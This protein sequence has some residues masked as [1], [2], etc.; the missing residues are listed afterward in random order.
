[1]NETVVKKDY[2][3][4]YTLLFVLLACTGIA[5]RI[6][7]H[8]FL[9]RALW[10]DEAHLSLN[11]I[12]GNIIDM[13]IPLKHFQSAPIL[14]L[15]SEEIFT[16]IFGFS[17]TALRT[18]P[19]LVSLL[20]YPLYY[21]FV[22]DLTKSRFTAIIAF[23]LL[24]FSAYAIHYSSETK[25][26][27]VELS[28]FIF[29]GFLLFSTNP[30]IA[31]RRE[32]LL[33]VWGSIFMFLANTSLVLLSSVIAYRIYTLL[34]IGKKAHPEAYAAQRK[35]NKKLFT[36]WGISFAADIILNIIINPY[37]D[38][39]RE[40]WEFAYIP[41][42]VF[43][44]GFVDFMSGRIHEIFFS[45]MLLFKDGWYFPYTLQ[46]IMLSGIVYTIR[47]KRFELLF[48]TVLP[49]LLH[50]GLSWMQ[51]YP[52]FFRF[53]LYLFPAIILWVAI[54]TTAIARWISKLH[55]SVA[56]VP[57][58]YILYCCIQP[59]MQQYP[60]TERN[61][62]PVLDFINKY[63]DTTKI[64]ITTPATLYEYYNKT[65]YVKDTNYSGLEWNLSP[66]EYYLS[67]RNQHKN[68]LLLYSDD[69]YAD[70]YARVLKSLKK[71]HMV[72]RAMEYG[73]YGVAELKP[74]DSLR[75]IP[76]A[77]RGITR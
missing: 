51:L 54:G 45:S 36:V 63:P 40:L 55:W 60:I 61:V 25:P 71:H 24:T 69:G 32:K 11:F 39:L 68:Y 33:K 52:L 10:E 74:I 44:T 16:T 76:P 70:G 1:M 7:Q 26:Y 31:A 77:K 73:T 27:T 56:I 9:G 14:F 6:Y 53:V 64:F 57:V 75:Y 3:K 21:Y 22:R 8:F 35:L 66:Q 34:I 15:L 49:I 50:L 42:N 20:A 38:N 23:A 2:R 30:Y 4:L 18:F 29:M 12:D 59:S 19:F 67:V 46:V 5:L 65:G 13:F 72:V 37:A 17:E 41:F 47:S 43:S 28:V 58:L 62:K 48:F